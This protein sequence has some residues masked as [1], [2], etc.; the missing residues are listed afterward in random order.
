MKTQLL[1]ALAALLL[2]PFSLSA[3]G[4]LGFGETDDSMQ[5]LAERVANIEQKFKSFN[6][7][8]NFNGNFHAMDPG[9]GSSTESGFQAKNLR[10]E[11]KGQIGDKFFYRV[12]QRLNKPTNALSDGLA[13]ATDYAM[14]GYRFNP[15]WMVSVGKMGQYF[16][17][18][19]FDQNAIYVYQASD[20]N[21]NADG[22]KLGMAVTYSPSSTQQLVLQVTNAFNAT[23]EEE[24]AGI[25][26]QGIS[27]SHNP[28][29]YVGN[30]SGSFA[31]GLYRAKAAVI[32]RQLATDNGSNVFTCGQS[33]NG[34]WGRVFLDYAYEHDDFDYMRFCSNEVRNYQNGK[35]LAA[36]QRY[37]TD[38][39]YHGIVARTDVKV[40]THLILWAEGMYQ[41]ASCA[42]VEELD[43]FRKHYNYMAGLEFVP[44]P[45]YK[46]RYTLNYQGQYFDYSDRC[47]LRDYS[48]NRIEVGILCRLK[49]F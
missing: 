26:A 43:G 42:S 44:N 25:T 40:G 39:T 41:T 4:E 34:A 2:L 38:L 21:D 29:T 12:R 32:H 46:I 31:E 15:Q 19:E 9:E 27:A 3:Q 18:F 8:V 48:T 1:L 37:L 28:L 24:Y 7:Y 47:G 23:L 5:S 30:W 6:V 13:K 17:G 10:L 16:A 20:I 14:V 11:M 49:C 45:S 36:N 22:S 33:I 35:Y